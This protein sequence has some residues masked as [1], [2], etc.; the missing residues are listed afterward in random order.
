MINTS[1]QITMSQDELQHLLEPLIRRVIREELI[2]I[3]KQHPDI[4]FLHP[5]MPIYDDMEDIAQRKAADTI[6]LFSHE[7][8][9]NG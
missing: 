5:D 6:E 7:E 1:Q 9:W 3:S 8:V 4:F 2:R